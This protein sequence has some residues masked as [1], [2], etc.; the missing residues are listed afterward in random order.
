MDPDIV[1]SLVRA[2]ELKDHSTAAHTW[3][4]VLYARAMAEAESLDKDLIERLTIGA[5]LHDLGKVDVPDG[6]LT[7][8]GRLTDEEFAVIKTHP[9]AGHR[10]LVG[11]GETDDVLLN[12]VR[13]HHERWDG[14]GYPDRLRGEA[15]PLGARYFA[16]IDTFDALTSV[17]PYRREV[18]E[19]A[20]ERAIAILQNGAGTHYWP[21]AVDLFVDLYRTG[22]LGWILHYFNDDVP[23]PGF[24]EEGR[25]E[26]PPETRNADGATRT[27]TDP[28]TRSA[29]SGGSGNAD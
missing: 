16:V 10:R 29:G 4:V 15:I 6:I 1:H 7:K 21:N 25:T 14:D 17:R 24:L 19:D 22:Q 20:A 9:D 18:G 11:M 2:I 28:E 3:R 27:P 12:L 26:Q 13:H 23:V 8:P 5:A